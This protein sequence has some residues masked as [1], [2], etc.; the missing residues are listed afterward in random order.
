VEATAGKFSL[1][2]LILTVAGAWGL[3]KMVKYLDK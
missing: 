1:G 3:W 2:F